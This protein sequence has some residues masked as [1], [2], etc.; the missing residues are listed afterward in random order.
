MSTKNAYFIAVQGHLVSQ[1]KLVM[2][3][4]R[5]SVTMEDVGIVIAMYIKTG[6]KSPT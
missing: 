1:N 3:L 2:W 6:V 5:Q 4:R